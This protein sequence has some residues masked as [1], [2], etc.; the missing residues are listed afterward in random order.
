M[1]PK[2]MWK[3]HRKIDVK[4]LDTAAALAFMF[5]LDKDNA[6]LPTMCKF[7]RDM[8]QWLQKRNDT[9]QEKRIALRTEI[10][11]CVKG[12][13]WRK[14]NTCNKKWQRAFIGVSEA[15]INLYDVSA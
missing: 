2:E 11:E 14:F 5:S 15:Q 8:R 7:Y 1:L 13:N 9:T 4:S 12:I 3:E 6:P 10:K